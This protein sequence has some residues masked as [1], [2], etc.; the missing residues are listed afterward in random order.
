[1]LVACEWFNFKFD[2]HLLFYI[3]VKLGLSRWGRNTVRKISGLK[4]GEV[5]GEWR[6]LH[7]DEL[8]DLHFSP[9]IIL[10]KNSRRI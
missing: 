1:V 10:I 3:D 4:R 6:R 5:P 9:D 8:H 2:T 7:N